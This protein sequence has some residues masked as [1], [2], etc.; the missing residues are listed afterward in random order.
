MQ[1]MPTILRDLPEIEYLDGRAH[2][3]VSPRLTHALVQSALLR[4]MA[5]A[6]ASRGVVVAELRVGL[7]A[8]DRSKTEFVPDVSFIS[9]ERLSRLSGEIR[10]KPPFSP[11]VAVEVRSPT[12]DLRYLARKIARY[13]ATGSVLVLDVDPPARRIVAHAA[14]GVRIFGPGETFAHPAAPWLCFSID[15]SFSDLDSPPSS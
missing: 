15:S 9:H 11:D 5:D 7:G 8:A 1:P 4:V 3:K 14:G 2:R 12:D 13:L 10:E 6:A